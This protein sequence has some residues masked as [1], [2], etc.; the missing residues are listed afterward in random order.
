MQMNC[1]S[2]IW[3]KSPAVLWWGGRCR[4]RI[5]RCHSAA[6][7]PARVVT[8]VAAAHEMLEKLPLGQALACPILKSRPLAM[9][10]SIALDQ[11][12]ASNLRKGQPQE[13]AQS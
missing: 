3:R 13:M 6:A 8:D 10:A 12:G 1:R 2:T 4:C 5:F 11:G 7:T 9:E